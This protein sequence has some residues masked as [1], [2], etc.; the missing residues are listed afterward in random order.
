[1]YNE[2]QQRIDRNALKAWR[3]SGIISST[4]YMLLFAIVLY[5]TLRFDW[6]VW[7]ALIAG[8]AAAVKSFLEIF[9]FPKL[10]YNQ[11]RYEINE[12]QIEL[13]HGIIFRIRTSIPMVRI[14]HVDTKQG[15]IMRRFGLSTV[16]FSTAAGS[17]EI[18]ALTEQAADQARLQIA[19]LARLSDEEI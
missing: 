7:I 17:H 2:P 12:H 13:R 19:K 6:P 4:V 14:Q 18:P 11:W 3:M 8:A 10:K 15:P 1:M 16:T 9:L 5:L